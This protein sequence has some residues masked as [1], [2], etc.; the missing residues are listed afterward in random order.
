MAAPAYR[1]ARRRPVCPPAI[2]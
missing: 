2:E 1:C